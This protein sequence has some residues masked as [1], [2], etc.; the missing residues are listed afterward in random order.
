MEEYHSISIIFCYCDRNVTLYATI[1]IGGWSYITEFLPVGNESVGPEGVTQRHQ[2]Q[3]GSRG[4]KVVAGGE[5]RTSDVRGRG[6]PGGD[7]VGDDVPPPEMGGD[8]QLHCASRDVE[9]G[10]LSCC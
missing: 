4:E 8:V 1:M 5:T 2:A 10:V 9:E 7:S 6:V 3:E